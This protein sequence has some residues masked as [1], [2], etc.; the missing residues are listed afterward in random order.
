MINDVQNTAPPYYEHEVTFNNVR[1]QV[2]LSGTLTVPNSGGPH[3]VVIILHGSGPFDRNCTAF[4]H[5]F[6][7]VWAHYLAEKGVASLRYDKRGVAKSSG[8]LS[9]STIENFAEDAKAGVDFLK[10]RMDIDSKQIGSI[11]HSEGGVTAALLA[12]KTQDIRFVV[13]LAAPCIKW[14]ELILSQEEKM[15]IHDGVSEK[16]RD[17]IVNF[18]KRGFEILRNTEDPYHAAELINDLYEKALAE[19]E[20]TEVERYYGPSS[21]QAAFFSSP[22]FRY[23]IINDPADT[24]KQVKVPILALNGTN[25]L[26][27]PV[28]P[29]LVRIESTLKEAHHPDYTIKVMPKLNHS[30]QPCVTGLQS[31]V[32]TIVE[33][34]NPEVFDMITNWIFKH[35]N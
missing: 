27:V 24:F 25:D 22:N 19:D 17:N 8:N 13:S 33:T 12:T 23:N 21:L 32:A 11:G 9:T 35:V 30:F 34:I 6:F 29:N 1:D 10:N 28:D 4:G 18:R 20:L 3:P 16:T 7:L 31:E 26:V 15:H 5:Q 2:Q 14:D